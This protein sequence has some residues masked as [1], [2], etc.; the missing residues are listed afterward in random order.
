MNMDAEL[1]EIP[2]QS[3]KSIQDTLQYCDHGA[4]CDQCDAVISTIRYK[5]TLCPD[6]DLC[7]QCF[8]QRED[9]ENDLLTK[10]TLNNLSIHPWNHL[11]LKIYF[12]LPPM[13]KRPNTGIKLL[14]PFQSSPVGT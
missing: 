2:I 1:V 14:Y 11:F 9:C 5:C 12:R 13:H 8:K 3:T 6:Y 10:S 4:I 7:T